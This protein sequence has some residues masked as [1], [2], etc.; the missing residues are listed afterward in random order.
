MP[1]TAS[2]SPSQVT[3]S[4]LQDKRHRGRNQRAHHRR[5]RIGRGERIPDLFFRSLFRR[6]PSHCNP[7]DFPDKCSFESAEEPRQGHNLWHNL[8]H[9]LCPRNGQ[10]RSLDSFSGTAW[11]GRRLAPRTPSQQADLGLVAYA[12]DGL[13]VAPPGSPQGVA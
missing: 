1:G 9:N 11:E 5:R 13:S 3:A 10:A 6:V 8:W 12:Q 4:Y 2:C 7:P